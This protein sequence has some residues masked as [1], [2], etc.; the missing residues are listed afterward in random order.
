LG[1]ALYTGQ[2]AWIGLVPILL[3]A[4]VCFAFPRLTRHGRVLAGLVMVGLSVGLGLHRFPGFQSLVIVE[5]VQLAS[6]IRIVQE[7]RL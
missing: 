1:V 6:E 3:L 7:V 2:L 4:V 5:Q